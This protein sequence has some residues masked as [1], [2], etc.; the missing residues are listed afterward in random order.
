MDPE[1]FRTYGH[2]VI[3]WVADYL[4]QVEQYPVLSKVAPGEIRAKLPSDPPLSGESMSEILQDFNEIILPGITHWNHPGFFAYFPANNSGPSILAELLSAGLGVNAMLWQTSP[5]ATELE[6][7][8]MEWLRK[9][10]ELPRDFRGVIQDTAS[11]ATLCALLCARERVSDF[12]INAEGFQ[13]WPA[14]TPLRLYTSREAHSSVEKGAKIAGFGSHNVVPISVDD[15]YAMDPRDLEENIRKDLDLGYIPCCVTATVGTTSS[16]ALDPLEPIGEI[17]HRYG[18]WFHVD[19]ALAGSAAILP[20]KR[21]ILDGIERAD[22]FVFN[23]HKWLFTNFDCSA[24]FCRR[25]EILTRT[26]SILPEYLKTDLDR[27]VTNFRDWGIQLGRRFRALKLWFVLRHYG[28]EGLRERVRE[29]IALAQQFKTWVENHPYFELLAPVPLNT[30]CFRFHPETAR[31]ARISDE[32]LDGLNKKLL[33]E[34]NRSGR[35][36]LTHT[37]LSDR[38]CLRLCVGQTQTRQKHV[39]EAWRTLLESDVVS[40]RNRP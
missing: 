8:V 33:D 29:H 1:H 6:E 37:K 30:I 40:K 35:M 2:Q 27:Q 12:R 36:F 20:E 14:E 24:F 16:T 32:E 21:W 26:F 7:L 28:V 25:P 9:M 15:R 13:S 10:L 19:A 31:D 11:T 34:V 4:Q 23:P 22:S 18:A 3:D 17:S 38:F 5:A 39:E